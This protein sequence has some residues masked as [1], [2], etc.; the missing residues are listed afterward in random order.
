[1]VTANILIAIGFVLI[2]AVLIVGFCAFLRELTELRAALE[3][4]KTQTIGVASEPTRY[5]HVTEI[6]TQALEPVLK[7]EECAACE[8]E[9]MIDRVQPS[10]LMLAIRVACAQAESA[11]P[12][13]ILN[14]NLRRRA[15]VKK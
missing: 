10:P 7:K 8:G 13:A 1:M 6:L 12:A 11:T 15:G 3:T 14:E 2:L 9:G 4:P 5:Q